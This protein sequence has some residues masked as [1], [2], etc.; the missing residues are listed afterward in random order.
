[1]TVQSPY[2]RTAPYLH[3]SWLKGVKALQESS[4]MGNIISSPMHKGSHPRDG[5]DG[6]RPAKRR[7][8]SSPDSFD[9]DHLIASPRTSESGSMLR[10][11]VLKILHKD[12]KKVKTYQSS[13]VPRDVLATKAR[14]RITILDVSC[15]SSKVLHC[16]SQICDLTTYKNPVGPHRLAR[17]D[18]PRPFYV[19]HESILIN[20]PDDGRFDASDSYQLLVELEA[21]NGVC[22]P[23][24]DS[25]D[26]GISTG[27]V[28]PPWGSSQYWVMSSRF[29]KVVGRLKHPLNLS[30][31]YPSDQS[32]FQTN[33]VMDVDLRW[34]SGFR[35]F[36][37]LDKESKPCIN[38]RDPDVD[39][40]ADANFEH[41]SDGAINGINGHANG[42][43]SHDLE[44]EF[45]GDQTPSRSLRTREKAKVYNLKVLSD[46]AQ[47]RERKKRGRSASSAANEGRVQYLLPSDQP[48][49]LDCFRCVSCGAYH[50]SMLQLQLHLQTA[51]PTYEYVLETTS[52][53]PQF[54][55]SAL[56]EVLTSP[57]KTP[58]LGR[59]VKPFNLST[60]T[61]TDQM[62]VASRLGH[63]IEEPFK[64][65]S[66]KAPVDRLQS[67]SPLPKGFKPAAR[68]T[69][70]PNTHKV[71]VPD[72][73]QRLFHPISKAQ[74][75]PGQEVPEIVPDDTWLIQK[76]R[77]SIGDFSDVTAAEKEYIW[78]WDG[79]ILRKKI[80]SVAYFPREWLDFVQQ[81]ATWLVAEEHR[82]LEFGKHSSVLLARDVLDATTTDRAF[83]YINDARAK[84][85]SAPEGPSDESG[86]LGATDG[87]T[88]Q[89]PRSSQIRKCANGCAVCQ[90]PVRGPTLLVCSNK[91]CSRRSYHAACIKKDAIMPVT[92]SNWLCNA[93]YETQ[94]P[95]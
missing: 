39:P 5:G 47:G 38:A 29:D 14:C 13:T 36:R 88:K 75:K 32:T 11:E 73:P 89:S 7:R 66:A 54:R 63:D 45:A 12:S 35:A 25:H 22:W 46:Q 44:D 1:M 55:V 28:Y 56:R 87:A 6:P 53:G 8:L 90:L 70:K 21:A 79:H 77:E 69:H 51:H 20:R 92:L 17:V 43:T 84:L 59:Q 52:Q 82:M 61:N 80:T 27:S 68:R 10:I 60:V 37:L 40:Y 64:S 24:L 41:P 74:L 71:L 58:K 4:V 65:P 15:G 30:P 86:S 23:P 48:V 57:S 85:K 94:G 67:G 31:T 81:K 2:Q 95:G 91:T 93:C 34:A 19:P 78:E 3:R 76:H 33:Y 50:E 49:C 18:L 16:Q 26:F 42:E 62:F 72:A 9:L 83:G